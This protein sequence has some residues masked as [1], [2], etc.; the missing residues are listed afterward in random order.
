MNQVCSV[1]HDMIVTTMSYFLI[2]FSCDIGGESKGEYG[3]TFWDRSSWRDG[4]L[5]CYS[6]LP[7]RRS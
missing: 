1:A 6:S 5:V 3:S 7:P 2:W 4:K